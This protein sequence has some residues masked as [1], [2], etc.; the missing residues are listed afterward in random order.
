MPV[1]EDGE[2]PLIMESSYYIETPP[3]HVKIYIISFIESFRKPEAE[4]MLHRWIATYNNNNTFR[5]HLLRFFKY[6]CII[7]I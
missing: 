1:D 2:V 5:I 7:L 4:D 3:P 6:S